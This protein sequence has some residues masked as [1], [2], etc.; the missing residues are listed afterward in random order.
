VV[1][2]KT[3]GDRFV[4][5]GYEYRSIKIF[6]LEKKELVHHFAYAHLGINLKE[7]CKN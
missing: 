6:D 7:F 1:S 5:A 3:F 2:L 4:V